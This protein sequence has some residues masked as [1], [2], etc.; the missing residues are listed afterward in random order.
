MGLTLEERLFLVECYFREE[1][2]TTGV[3]EQFSK[4]KIPETT[5]PNR[6]TVR[7][8]I[9]KFHETGSAGNIK[10]IGRPSVLTEDKPLNISDSVMQSPSKSFRKLAQ[11]HRIADSTAYI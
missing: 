11:H 3:R 7:A 1:Q 5:V 8:V 2:Y 10:R 9:E 6:H 4:K